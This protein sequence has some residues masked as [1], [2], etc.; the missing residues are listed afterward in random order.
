MFGTEFRRTQ[1]IESAKRSKG[2]HGGW[3]TIGCPQPPAKAGWPYS[4]WL[5]FSAGPQQHIIERSW[6]RTGHDDIGVVSNAACDTVASKA[7][8]PEAI[9][10]GTVDERPLPTVRRAIRISVSGWNDTQVSWQT[11][12]LV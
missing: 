5:F 7:F 2:Q 8:E 6:T 10:L 12:V 11:A 1:P 9:A 3:V 4:L